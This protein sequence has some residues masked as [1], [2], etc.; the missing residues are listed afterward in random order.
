MPRAVSH[1]G[2]LINQCADAQIDGRRD[3]ETILVG[4]EIV[5]LTVR[6]IGKLA[7]GVDLVHESESL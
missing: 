6:I 1:Y 7:L 2:D 4:K 3:G 5:R